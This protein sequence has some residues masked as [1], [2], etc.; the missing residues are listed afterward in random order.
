MIYV[1]IKNFTYKETQVI[2]VFSDITSVF[3]FC[4]TKFLFFQL[5]IFNEMDTQSPLY[6]DEFYIFDHDLKEY[7]LIN[8]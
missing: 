5:R 8:L 1:I 3:N 6:K 7:K 4:K 2:A